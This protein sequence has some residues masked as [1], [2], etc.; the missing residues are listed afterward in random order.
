MHGALNRRRRGREISITLVGAGPR[1]VR[2][3][4][5]A[6]DG[7][8]VQLAEPEPHPASTHTRTSGRNWN[9]LIRVGS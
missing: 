9:R 1:T 6:P 4:G 5:S 3:G 7:R 2:W 8:G